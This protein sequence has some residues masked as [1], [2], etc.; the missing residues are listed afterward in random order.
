ML[1]VLW[2]YDGILEA[3]VDHS[4]IFSLWRS[5]K[6]TPKPQLKDGVQT[7]ACNTFDG[8]TEEGCFR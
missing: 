2:R 4:R 3:T 6:Y 7:R 5:A 8:A 1:G